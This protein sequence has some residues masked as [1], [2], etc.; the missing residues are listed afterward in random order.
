M[1]TIWSW[2]GDFPQVAHVG[3][4]VHPTI[5]WNKSPG[6]NWSPWYRLTTALQMLLLW[7]APSPFNRRKLKDLPFKRLEADM[8]T[9][10]MKRYVFFW[11]GWN[12][13]MSECWEY[14]TRMIWGIWFKRVEGQWKI[15]WQQQEGCEVKGKSCRVGVVGD[16]YES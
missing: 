11:G 4:G 15:F 8:N 6:T 12:M 3:I 5:A 1:P 2:Y 7:L 16:G 9:W 14:G 13:N 10:L